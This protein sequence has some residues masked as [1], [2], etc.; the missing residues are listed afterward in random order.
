MVLSFDADGSLLTT[1]SEQDLFVAQTSDLTYWCKVNLHNLVSGDAVRIKTYVNDS[2]ATTPRIIYNDRVSFS[3]I[4]GDPVYY[5]P[6]I[7]TDSFK[8]TIQR[9]AGSDRTIT[10]RRGSY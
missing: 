8:V 3:H 5:I 9:V 2:N 7:P 1:A 6:P 4:N 10:W